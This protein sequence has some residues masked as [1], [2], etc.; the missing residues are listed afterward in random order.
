MLNKANFL[1][2]DF[3]SKEESRYSLTA[4]QIRPEATVATNGHYLA[5]VSTNRSMAPADFPQVEGFE[6]GD[7]DFTPFL[8]ETDCAKAIAKALPRK[9]T[10][11]I[12]SYA[13]VHKNGGPASI[14]V[15]DLQNPQVFHPKPVEG[16]YP[17][18]ERVV[19]KIEDE[20]FSICVNAAYLQDIAK[21]YAQFTKG[22]RNQI[23]RIRFYGPSDSIRFDATND[24]G[25]GM[26]AV[27]MP[28]RDERKDYLGTHGYAER[29]AKREQSKS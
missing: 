10:I 8:L 23:M 12:L 5:W 25:Q 1:V 15:T 16:Q 24:D 4:V 29:Q 20:K 22:D 28:L 11:P 21:A 2:T 27:L 6:G 14:C 7:K 13:A 18:I 26:T 19:P 17:D 3:A 9:N